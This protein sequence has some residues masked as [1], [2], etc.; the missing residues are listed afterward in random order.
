VVQPTAHA[1]KAQRLCIL[2]SGGKRSPTLCGVGDDTNFRRVLKRAAQQFLALGAQKRPPAKFPDG[3]A[4]S[5]FVADKDS[6]TDLLALKMTDFNHLR[7]PR[8]TMRGA[9]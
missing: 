2:W 3:I 1:P 4:T 7:N 8:P 6:K 5:E 9:P